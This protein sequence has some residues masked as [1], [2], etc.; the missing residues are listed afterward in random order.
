[1][2][3]ATWNCNGRF[4]DKVGRALA[5]DC[6]IT[7]IQEAEDP[8]YYRDQLTGPWAWTDAGWGKGV[9]AFVK[10]GW[11]LQRHP[12]A[13]AQPSFKHVVP[14][15]AVAPDGSHLA[16]WAVWC[17]DADNKADA[18]VAQLHHGL[19]AMQYLI[20]SPVVIAGDLNSNVVWDR[21]RHL[22]HSRLIA[23]LGEKRIRSAYHLATGEQAGD[24][25]QPTFWMARSVSKP[26]HL[27]YVFT[28]LPVKSV[29]VGSHAEWSGLKEDGGV[30]DHAPLIAE[31]DLG[32]SS[33]SDPGYLSR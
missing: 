20:T 18:W 14:L 30:S 7:L 32:A 21:G 29:A 31:L 25:S 3:I 24:E 5:L 6:D 10:S 16:V 23:R 1:M 17:M 22:N 4:R 15:D 9:L 13:P 26:F 8:H 27:D 33:V 2:R 19:D 11:S 28:D 12:D